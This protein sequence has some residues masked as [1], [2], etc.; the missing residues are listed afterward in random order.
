MIEKSQDIKLYRRI[1]KIID[2]CKTMQQFEVA[3]N[4]LNLAGSK[5]YISHE[6]YYELSVY[7]SVI[8]YIMLEK[9]GL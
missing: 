9:E 8:S 3:L 5:K 2:S 7:S 6:M 4:Y 1:K